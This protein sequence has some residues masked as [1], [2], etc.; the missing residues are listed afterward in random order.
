MFWIIGLSD[1]VE[2]SKIEAET[3]KEAIEI[4]LEWWSERAPDV[5]Y[6]IEDEGE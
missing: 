1:D 3:K 6:C 4:A 2:Y 5:L